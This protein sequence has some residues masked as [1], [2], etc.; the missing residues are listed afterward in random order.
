MRLTPKEKSLI[1]KLRKE[2]IQHLKGVAYHLARN[3]HLASLSLLDK[4]DT[5][6]RTIREIKAGLYQDIGAQK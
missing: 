2:I 3:D 6:R 5:A 4:V 1:T